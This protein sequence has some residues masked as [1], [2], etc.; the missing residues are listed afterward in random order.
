M[1][2]ALAQIGCTQ[3]SGDSVSPTIQVHAHRGG[4]ALRPENTLSAFHTSIQ[5]VGV[6]AV[7]LDVH[8]TSD[9]H[10]VINHDFKVNHQFCLTSQGK[11]IVSAPQISHITFAQ[12]RAYDCGTLV[13][14]PQGTPMPTLDEVFSSTSSL[15]GPSGQLT[16]YDL[17]IKWDR[18]TINASDYAALILNTIGSHGVLARVHLMSDSPEL[19]AAAKLQEPSLS[20]YFLV[21]TVGAAE[22]QAATSL[23]VDAVLPQGQ[24]LTLTTVQQLHKLN[25]KVIAWTVDQPYAWISLAHMGVDG[26][27][28]DNPLG[29]RE[30]V[31]GN[32]AP[33]AI[34][35]LMPIGD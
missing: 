33:L 16:Q 7:E 11:A 10:L 18:T 27:I 31:E 3:G 22:I 20:L 14:L 2:L 34:G 23:Q 21:N 12:L 8:Q 35:E 25:M 30:L 6:D 15:Q 5:D 13:G 9:Q 29:L 28:T 4:A 17:H 19:L 26:I 1:F 24:S 32:K